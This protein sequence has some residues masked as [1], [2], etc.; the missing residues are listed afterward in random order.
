MLVVAGSIL[1][2]LSGRVPY[3]VSYPMMHV[4]LPSPLSLVDRMIDTRENIAF[5]Q[6]LLRVIKTKKTDSQEIKLWRW[7]IEP[8]C[9]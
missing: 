3:H 7:H 8:D 9:F 6:L 5:P 1:G 4:M 2:P